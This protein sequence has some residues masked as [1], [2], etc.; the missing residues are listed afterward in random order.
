MAVFMIAQQIVGTSFSILP[1]G[2]QVVGEATV[3]G[4]TQAGVV[5]V[6]TSA[7]VIVFAL[8]LPVLILHATPEFLK[9]R[10]WL[11]LIPLVVFP[12]AIAFTFDRNMWL[13]TALGCLIYILLAH[14]KSIR[15]MSILLILALGVMLMVSLLD[16]YFP[17]IDDVTAAIGNRFNSLFAGS[18]LVN[19]SSTQWRLMENEYAIPVI[20]EN[21][22]LGLGPHAEYRP[23][24][25]KP[26]DHLTH[27][28][29][30]GYLWILVDFGIMGFLPFL[31][32]SIAHLAMG[33]R[34]WYTL[35]DPVLR[36]LVAGLTASYVG[37]LIS[38][39]VAPRFL[40]IH[41]S[42]LVSIILGMSQVAIRLDRQ[43]DKK[44]GQG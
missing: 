9:N 26:A 18:D 11:T 42:L 27:Y 32:F 17:R 34:S 20:L 39:L 19:D 38:N 22:V 44:T 3:L 33:V 29:H 28:V 31:W 35:R 14:I 21:P 8:F 43:V 36:G 15:I 6:S 7:A 5:R 25:R 40:T 12:I 10:K 30:N 1:A 2:E 41:G 4:K 37:L 16:D 24:V 23:A 13:G